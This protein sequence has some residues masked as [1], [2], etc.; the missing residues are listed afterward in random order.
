MNPRQ[1]IPLE[2]KLAYHDSKEELPG[3]GAWFKATVPGAV[4]LDTS[5]A[6][7]LPDYQTGTNCEQWEWMQD[8]FWTYRCELPKIHKAD[9]QSVFWIAEGIDY[10]FEMYLDGER[11]HTQEGM[12][13][14]VGLDVTKSLRAGSI[15]EIRVFP[16]PRWKPDA[17][18]HTQALYSVKPPVS[19]GWDWHPH[20]V[21]LGI[22]KPCYL[23]VRNRSHFKQAELN[24]RL[25]DDF[26]S[27]AIQFETDTHYA[28]NTRIRWTLS[29]A[30]GCICLE[31]ED[32]SNGFAANAATELKSPELWWPHDHG[33]PYLYTSKWVLIDA[34]N[35]VLDRK[36]TKIGFRKI[37]MVMGEGTWETPDPDHFPKT[38]SPAPMT[39]EINGKRIFCKGSNWVNPDIFPGRIERNNC[40]DLLSIA[41]ST[42]FN[43]LR[44]WGGAPVNK[45]CFYEICN[46]MGLL[47]WQD[48][49][50]AC[51]PYPDDPHYL[52]ILN[53]ESRSII[54]ALRGHPSLILWCGGNELFNRWS[55]MHDQSLPLRLLNRNCYELDP[56]RPF[57][58]TA[59]IEGMAHGH[60]V[61]RDPNTGKEA[62]ECFQNS[63]CTAYSEFGMPGPADLEY[64]RS[65]IPEN[66]L[67]YPP[68]GDVW[69]K[70]HAANAWPTEPESWLCRSAIEYYFGPSR[71]LETLLKNGRI[72]QG[73][74]YQGL[75]EEAR[76]QKPYCS[77]ALN[78]CFNEPWPTAANNSLLSWPAIPKPA[79]EKVKQACRPTL[80][81]A[82]V[83]K[84]KWQVGENFQAE[85]WIL[86]DSNK[87][88]KPGIVEVSLRTQGRELERFQWHHPHCEANQ[89]LKGPILQWKLSPELKDQF[90]LSLVSESFSEGN[91]DYLFFAVADNS[92]SE[93]KL[94]GFNR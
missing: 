32:E 84:A 81:S 29:D 55:G 11:L 7:N 5:A 92:L 45:D 72:L 47:V 25:A 37:R 56:D 23:E 50:L 85:L 16:A 31:H 59:P 71:D 68:Q 78:W 38:R 89:N 58:P 90:Q 43:L 41:K 12:F 52:E 94:P 8:K 20:L 34:S 75:Y 73:I 74:G 22:W 64:L 15:L 2:W 62:W 53:Q 65:F 36:V 46:E 10:Q 39:V 17:K 83:K 54:K 60:Y 76:R 70:H 27:A 1:K 44:I 82:R 30:N 6:E 91:N 24:Y 77:M 28:E 69:T 67:Q 42:H 35:R 87:E 93:D 18:D 79:L 49:P 61:F 14:P 40:Q 57:I 9:S 80:F 33:T 48:F 86:N 88:L 51:L 13:T 3:P 26:S 66:Q 4:Q 21:P 63:K 19:Y